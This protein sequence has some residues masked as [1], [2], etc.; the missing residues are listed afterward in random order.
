MRAS[1]A[2][3]KWSWM[4]IA[5]WASACGR[6]HKSVIG[7]PDPGAPFVC[8]ASAST[9]LTLR[10]VATGL[11]SPLLIT[12]PPGDDRLFIVQQPGQ[13]AI[14]TLNGNLR[15]T[16][17]LDITDRVA[18][19]RNEQGLLG[20][21]FHPDY[22]H[23]GR[24]F[25]YYTAASSPA[26]PGATVVAEYQVS[27]NPN[28]AD[29][30]SE[31][32]LIEIAHGFPNHNG[33]MLAFGPHDHFLY[34]GTG[35]GGSE[36]D[37]DFNA[38]NPARM[39]GKLLRID[40]DRGTPYA[41]PPANPFASSANGPD[42]PRP[43]VW[44]FGLRNP[45]RYSFDR[46]SRD[47]WI[48]DVGQDTYEE[49]DMQPAD[50]TGGENYGWNP[51]EARHCFNPPTGCIMLGK[52]LPVSEYT[53]TGGKCAVIGGY[54]YR[55]A[56]LQAYQGQ[57][58]FGDYCTNQIWAFLPNGAN[59]DSPPEL[60]SNIGPGISGLSSFGEDA[61]GELY[62]ASLSSGTVYQIVPK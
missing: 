41:V 61:H 14:V 6:A 22:A 1:E 36:G 2:Y 25:I 5:L 53:H 9:E 33:G 39:L 62:V 31:V 18:Y 47:L 60:T 48:G 21:A 52:V 4:L 11:T 37:P 16:P 45:W 42:D 54:V 40:V 7:E 43:E 56:C 27:S 13:I 17:F 32:R 35:D 26:G 57:Y 46:A 24:F 3:A 20:L 34:V 19:D 8:P 15:P 55:G 23:N 12:S 58:F 59:N 51:M 29:P 38:Q 30:T 44:A 50:S 28:V 10:T 49:I